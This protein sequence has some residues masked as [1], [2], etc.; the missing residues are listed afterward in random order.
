MYVIDCGCGY[1]CTHAMPHHTTSAVWSQALAGSC[2]YLWIFCQPFSFFFRLNFLDSWQGVQ[3][4]MNELISTSLVSGKL[5]RFNL[6]VVQIQMT[7][8]FLAFVIKTPSWL[9]FTPNMITFP[10]GI[11]DIDNR[12]CGRQKQFLFS[13]LLPVSAPLSLGDCPVST[14]AALI[15]CR[16]LVKYYYQAIAV[17]CFGVSLTLAHAHL[18]THSLTHTHTTHANTSTCMH[19][20]SWGHIRGRGVHLSEYP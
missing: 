7:F 13:L 2:L 18:L 9:Y 17:S 5:H 3:S 16:W 14:Q 19:R 1:Q 12:L 11:D 4:I 6:I 20:C 8:V 10:D 15:E